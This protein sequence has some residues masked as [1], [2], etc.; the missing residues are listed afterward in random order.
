[1]GCQ[2]RLLGFCRPMKAS[3]DFSEEPRR[4]GTWSRPSAARTPGA[5]ST[6]RTS[7][8]RSPWKPSRETVIREGVAPATSRLLWSMVPR[9]ESTSPE[10]AVTTATI[11]PTP[12]A[13]SRVRRGAR[14]TLRIGICTSADP[15]TCSRLPIAAR[16]LEPAE[17]NPIRI[18][19][20][21]GTRTP[22]QTGKAVATIGRIRPSSAPRMKTCSSNGVRITGRGRRSSRAPRNTSPASRP[23][24][25]PRTVPAK[26]ISAPS[27]SG[28]IASS[29]DG[30]PSAIPTPISRRWASTIRLARLKAA[31][32]A[33]ARI[34]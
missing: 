29:H 26:A 14:S 12:S 16:P 11:V 18:A 20:I 28:R 1:M 13:V 17:R 5:P 2:S 23:S 8:E 24:A 6:E 32:A 7:A 15:G 25:R 4:P 9:N 31:K 34:R 27:R 33:P 19:S 21:G 3:N 10:K 30:T 22:R